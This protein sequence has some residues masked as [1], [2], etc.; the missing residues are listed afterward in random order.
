M[1][2]LPDIDQIVKQTGTLLSFP[3]V[4][5]QI[6]EMVDDPACSAIAIGEVLSRDSGL[7]A[8]LLKIV[9]SPLYGFATRIDTV[10]RAI[11]IIGL[12]ELRILVTTASAVETFSKISTQLIDMETF[13]RHSIFCAVIARV[14]AERCNVLHGERLFISGLLHDIGSLVIYQSLPMQAENILNQLCEEPA[15]S[16]HL[17]EIE[18]LGFDHAR[19]GAALLKNWHLPDS[20]CESIEF[21]HK[22]DEAE[23]HVLEAAIVSVANAMTGLADKESIEQPVY[24]I[25]KLRKIIQDESKHSLEGVKNSK[26]WKLTKL[27]SQGMNSILD[28]AAEKFDLALDAIYPK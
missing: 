23:Q 4:C 6:N 19:L 7:T 22:P 13:W 25:T 8:R 15:K 17:L 28:E 5:F 3:D 16:Q 11:S 21:H 18:N 24:F 26:A 10:S 20:I 9:N 2:E 12:R 27:D 14:L 1:S